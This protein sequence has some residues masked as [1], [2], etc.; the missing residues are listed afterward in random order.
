MILLGFSGVATTAALVGA[1][2]RHPAIGVAVL[3]GAFVVSGFAFP[4]AHPPR[5]RVGSLTLYSL[6]LATL[7]VLTALGLRAARGASLGGVPRSLWL[8]AGLLA[9]STA[10]GIHTFGLQAA[11]NGSRAWW[12][13]VASALYGAA[14]PWDD[15][16]SR[17]LQIFGVILIAIAGWGAFKYGVNSSADLRL[18]NG[19]SL[20]LRPLTSGGALLLLQIVLV[21]GWRAWPLKKSFLLLAIVSLVAVQQRTVWIAGAVVLPILAV[22][23][24]AN[25]KRFRPERAYA[26]IGLALLLLPVVV[27]G[28]TRSHTLAVSV[29]TAQG[30][31][32]TLHWRLASWGATLHLLRP[33]DWLLGLP[34]GAPLTRTFLGQVSNAEPHNLYVEAVARLGFLGLAAVVCIGLAAVRGIRRAPVAP[35]P[36]WVGYT[37][38]MSAA[39]YG[40][41]YG[42]SVAAGVTLGLV[43]GA[44]RVTQ[45]VRSRALTPVTAAE[46]LAV[47]R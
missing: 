2:H 45:T 24:L 44:G 43:L 18:V 31:H 7:V 34:A 20:T 17:V 5:I 38:V 29:H 22:R 33:V 16:L 28:L 35:W 36:R 10:H 42:P 30:S 13:L 4:L 6:D 21:A 8:L 32:S 39:I 1:V 41:S 11:A 15:A 23:W 27:A 47:S 46:P 12:W 14:V 26:A 40:V 37:M 25:E 19:E 9:A 3:L